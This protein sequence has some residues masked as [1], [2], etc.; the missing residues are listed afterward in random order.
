MPDIWH[1]PTHPAPRPGHRGR[2]RPLWRDLIDML[3]EVA[4]G[5]H[6]ER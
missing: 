1:Y 2:P 4:P 3:A 5:K 6:Q